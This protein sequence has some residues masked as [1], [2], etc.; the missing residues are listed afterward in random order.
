MKEKKCKEKSKL[1]ATFISEK[2]GNFLF[3][4]VENLHSCKTDF[5]FSFS[6][7]GR[8]FQSNVDDVAITGMYL[9]SVSLKNQDSNA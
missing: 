5:R 2:R 3:V 6:L 7:N 8:V 9:I 4:K 1:R